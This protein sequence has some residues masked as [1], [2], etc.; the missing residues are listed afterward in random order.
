M[1][2]W[3]AIGVALALKALAVGIVVRVLAALGVG[4]V[5]FTGLDLL[6]SGVESSLW[7]AY[8]DVNSLSATLWTLASIMNADVLVQALVSAAATVLALRTLGGVTKAW[9]LT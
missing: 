9:R 6:F 7:S 2:G 4:I 5:T 3:I 1:A 8:G